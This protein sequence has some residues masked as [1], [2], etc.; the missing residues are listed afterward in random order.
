MVHRLFCG[1]WRNLMFNRCLRSV[2][3]GGYFLVM[4]LRIA[5]RAAISQRVKNIRA[6]KAERPGILQQTDFVGPFYIKGSKKFYSMNTIDIV[7]NCCAVEPATEGKHTLVSLVW[8]TWKR[9]GMPAYQQVDN[10][11]VFYGSP[12]YPRGMGKLIRLCLHYGVEPCFI[13]IK[14]PWR[15][16]VVE[17]FNNHWRYKFLNRKTMRTVEDIKRESLLFEQKHNS[18]YQYRKLEGKTP[19]KAFSNSNIMYDILQ[20]SFLLICPCRNLKLVAIMYFVISAVMVFWIFLANIFQ[21]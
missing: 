17:R 1:D 15:N 5:V 12:R 4:I 2:R 9:L 19:L 13:P 7:T 20:P 14:E 16:G 11:M 18:R 6:L 21:R 10:E 3:L 8:N